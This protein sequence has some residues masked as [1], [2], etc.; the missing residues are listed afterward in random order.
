MISAQENDLLT[1]VGAG[2]P[3][4]EM[5]RRYWHVVCPTAELAGDQRTRRVSL[6]GEKLVAYRDRS[7]TYGLVE[8]R[9]PHRNASLYYGYVEEAGIRCAYHGWMFDETGACMEQPFEPKQESTREGF[10]HTAYPVQELAGLLFT[11]MGP[12]PAPQLPRWDV[13]ARGDG[14]RVLEV[15]PDLDCNWLQCQENSLD[16]V[17]THYLHVRRM[18]EKGLWEPKTLRAP[19][20]YAFQQFELGIVK[21]RVFGDDG[22]VAWTQLGHPAIFPNIL[23][24]VIERPGPSGVADADSISALPIDLQIRVPRDDTHT[25]IYVMYF[26]PNDD[27]RDDPKAFEPQVD[28]IQTKDEAGNF[29][30]TSFPSQD[31][32]AWETQGPITDR[33]LERLGVSDTGIVMWRRLMHDQIGVVQDGGEPIGV[34]RGLAENEIIDLGPSRE[35][36][37]ERWITKLWG[38]WGE[39]S[40]WES[41]DVKRSR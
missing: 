14:T 9:C 13:L 2:T 35:W 29:H 32:M 41:P 17:H 15:H 4:G 31:E 20:R 5:L 10:H 18:V 34:F 30:L 1:A 40:V 23:R 24:H 11:Y 21:K 38:G 3:G 12:Q 27:G 19:Q 37:G 33:T 7:G 25:Q 39:T 26:T 22:D 16:P 36:N 8:E 28:Y 6:L